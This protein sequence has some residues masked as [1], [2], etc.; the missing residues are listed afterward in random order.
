MNHNNSNSNSNSNS[1]KNN[2]PSSSS[3][4]LSLTSTTAVR[5]HL[6]AC[7]LCTLPYSI[8]RQ[9]LASLCGHSV[10]RSCVLAWK[11]AKRRDNIRVK[12]M[13]CPT[14]RKKEAF[15]SEEL[16]LNKRAWEALQAIDIEQQQRKQTRKERDNRLDDDSTINFTKCEQCHNEFST[17]PNNTN[18]LSPVMG[19]CGCTLCRSCVQHMHSWIMQQRQRFD[20]KWLDCPNHNCQNPNNN[21]NNHHNKP[22]KQCYYATE[23]NR[24]VLLCDAME[25]WKQ[26]QQKG[27]TGG[28]QEGE[29]KEEEE[30]GE[31]EVYQ[32]MM[33]AQKR[34]EERRALEMAIKQEQAEEEERETSH[35]ATT[36]TATATATEGSPD[37]TL[38]QALND[39]DN[40][41]DHSKGSSQEELQEEEDYQSANPSVKQEAALVNVKV[42]REDDGAV[43][44]NL[45]V[46][47]EEYSPSST[48]NEVPS[49]EVPQNNDESHHWI[50]QESTQ[51]E[52]E[53]EE[54]TADLDDNNHDGNVNRSVR[55]KA[56]PQSPKNGE[57]LVRN[58]EHHQQKKKSPELASSENNESQQN[59]TSPP[60][61]RPP[62]KKK[63]LK[64]QREKEK[65][66]RNSTTPDR[67]RKDSQDFTK[68]PSQNEE[69]PDLRPP[70][71][72]RFRDEANR[73]TMSVVAGAEASDR[74]GVERWSTMSSTN[75]NNRNDTITTTS[76]TRNIDPRNSVEIKK[77]NIQSDN[78]MNQQKRARLLYPQ[79]KYP[80]AMDP[81]PAENLIQ[82]QSMKVKFPVHI[83]D[84]AFIQ[85]H[86]FGPEDRIVKA[87]NQKYNCEIGKLQGSA[88]PGPYSAR[89]ED[90]LFL[91]MSGTYMQACRDDMERILMQA[92][93]PKVRSYFLYEMAKRNKPSSESWHGIFGA[94]HPERPGD[95]CYLWCVQAGNRTDLSRETPIVSLQAVKSHL[96]NL[97]IRHNLCL[98]GVVERCQM[99]PFLK[100][101][102]Y[103][104]GST[105]KSRN[106]T[107]EDMVVKKAVQACQ[108]DLLEKV[109]MMPKNDTEDDAW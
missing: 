38:N 17:E 43:G 92:L 102:V 20:I 76:A 2:N 107:A 6:I 28:C 72:K 57:K 105:V 52:E 101:F 58:E 85:R 62:R 94:Q 53:E 71:K 97:Q 26:W 50:K 61:L 18:P 67:K 48:E 106:N 12:N 4:S 82:A 90:P 13:P 59:D 11:D 45:V 23:L 39:D 56:E 91:S 44:H 34:H 73:S 79:L 108:V 96:T 10:C 24:N 60:D 103:I 3:S 54:D 40:I 5:R 19:R 64:E 69:S 41:S 84:A 89:L 88:F 83:T 68:R 51:E 86:L 99:L 47:Q 95:Y 32:Q 22:I 1:N 63:F 104:Y 100:P 35:T 42:E 49:N 27:Q 109:E 21:N 81:V 7:P 25:V 9:P 30:D 55:V 29:N 93:E 78:N 33:D 37:M 80:P 66:S 87:L 74:N 14:C 70:R 15:K 75:N 98:L 77:E 16:Y 65:D 31:E 8:D 46:K 36:T